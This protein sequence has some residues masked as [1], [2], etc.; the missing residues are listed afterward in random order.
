M[1]GEGW[2]ASRKQTKALRRPRLRIGAPYCMRPLTGW[3]EDAG[4]SIIA[5]AA[6]RGP[7]GSVNLTNKQRR[8]VLQCHPAVL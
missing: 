2:L 3:Q 1:R 8:I 5:Q 7:Q 6:R 4:V